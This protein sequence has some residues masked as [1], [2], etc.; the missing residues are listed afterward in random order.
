[1][2]VDIGGGTTDVSV[3]SL[4]RRGVISYSI[5]AGGV[6]M[7]EAIINF[8]KRELS[9]S[10][11]GDRTAEEVKL[12]LTPR[13]QSDRRTAGAYPRR[14]MVTNLPQTTEITSTQIYQGRYTSPAPAIFGRHQQV[15]ERTLPEEQT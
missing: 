12:D 15:L 13:C 3:I 5:R 10:L 11:I 7:D 2:I 4:W 6:K 14:D 1:M 8:I 9:T